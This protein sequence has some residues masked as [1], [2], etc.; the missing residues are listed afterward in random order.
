[1]NWW[2][3]IYCVIF[4]NSLVL[5]LEEELDDSN[6]DWTCP[7][8]R[9]LF[10]DPA[11]PRNLREPI[12]SAVDKSCPRPAPNRC[13]SRLH[14]C[15][16]FSPFLWFPVDFHDLSSCLSP[17]REPGMGRSPLRAQD[18]MAN[19]PEHL[20]LLRRMGVSL[21]HLKDGRV[22]LVQH[23]TQVYRFA[24]RKN[25]KKHNLWNIAYFSY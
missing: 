12:R 14:G 18:F 23:A 15:I 2:I 20:E 10:P 22:Q 17:F 13:V 9:L 4:H 7:N 24:T 6:F 8:T 19:N 1:M 3:P 25:I 11:F 21:I 5:Q 16:Y